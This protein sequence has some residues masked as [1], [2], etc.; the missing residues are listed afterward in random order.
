[1][2]TRWTQ[3][4][5]IL[6]LLLCM[7]PGL[8]G[9]SGTVKSGS[10]PIPGATVRAT[11]D[12][13]VLTTLTDA[14]G[15]F[16]LDKMTPGM[17]RVEVL[18][19]GFE[20][21]RRDVE[22][23]SAPLRLDVALQIGATPAAILAGAGARLAPGGGPGNGPGRGGFAQRGGEGRAGGRGGFPGAAGA[24]FPRRPG[25]PDAGAPGAGGTGP[26][27]QA[28]APQQRGNDN[29]PFNANAANA[30]PAN[31]SPN[32]NAANA[33]P[34]IE[35]GG[36]EPQVDV[37]SEAAAPV[38][39]DASGANESFLVN[40][41]LSTGLNTNEADF[42]PGFGFNGIGA[43]AAAGGAN[44]PGVEG[45]QA[46]P[47]GFG[48][49]IP[50]GFPGGGAPVG[51]PPGGF[52]GG[53]PR[54]GGGG[55]AGPG[56]GGRGPGGPQGNGGFIGNRRNAG[57]PALR[58]SVFFALRNSVADAAPYSINGQTG[59]KAAYAQN[60][61]GANIG[62]PLWGNTFFFLN[63]TGNLLRNG[64]NMTGTVPTLAQRG[65]DFSA[66]G[67]IL[68][69]PQSGLPFLNNQIPLNRI[70]SIAQGLLAYIPAPNQPGTVNN[71]R[72][73][74]AN[75]SNNQALNGRVQ[76]PYGRRDQ[77]GV[78]LNWQ[79]RDAQ[80]AQMFGFTDSS[81]GSGINGNINWRHNFGNARFNNLSLTFNRN[82]STA[83]PY[84]ANGANIAAQLGIQGTSSDPINFGPPNL[85]FTN[86]AG[87]T[88]GSPSRSA[89]T[90]FGFTES[91]LLR[92]GRHNWNL[93]GGLTRT[94]NYTVTD[95]NGRGT[96]TF[97]GLGTSQLN[98]NG[99][100][101]NGTGLDFADFLL[102]LPQ[103][104]SIRY[105]SSAM[106]F[107]SYSW[108]AYAQDDWR[109]NA[110][111]S[112]NLGLRYEYFAP[113]QEKYSR[114][115]NLDIAPGFTAAQV[116]TPGITAPYSGVNA[117]GL[118]QPDR[119]NFGPRTALAY[120]PW[121]KHSTLFR[122]GYGIYYN[123]GIYNQFM[124]RL[125][126][127]PP[128]AQST[129]VTTTLTNPLTLASGLTVLP[130]GKTILNTFAV[131]PLYRTMYAQSW[132]AAIQTNLTAAWVMEVS[133]LGTKG[134]R[135]DV[136]V[137]PNQA[138]PGSPLT[139]LDRTII[140][141]A[142]S[143]VYDTPVGNSIYH[144]GQVR[145]NRRFRRGTSGSVQY[146]FAKSIDNSSTLGGA[147]NSIAQN[148]YNLSAE[149]GL[150]SFNR[151]HSLTGNFVVN[152]PVGGPNGILANRGALTKALTGW[153][154][155][156]SVTLQT[157]TPLTARV[158]GNQSDTA[159]T[160][161][162]GSGRASA[163]GL[164]VDSGSGFFNLAAFTLPAPGQYGNAGRNT[165]PGPNSFTLNASLQRTI[166]LNERIRMQI[167]V[168]ATNVTNHPN[169]TGF[170]TVV[171]SIN[172]GAP[173]SVAGMRTMML[174]LRFNF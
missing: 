102:G 152:S 128:F 150:S 6:S 148:F 134:T 173:T 147:G 160:G 78:G 43:T 117:A 71:F 47:G 3:L 65:G 42:R 18:M 21:M 109:V 121:T 67:S 100:A 57:R 126:Q 119:N 41:S 52:G 157:G 12:D 149:R 16:T 48:G 11:Q 151:S 36:A 69:D 172:Y 125:A 14:N 49:G 35:G 108:N 56:R 146:L 105:G 68:Y 96:F 13:R 136:Q 92:I 75:P 9:Q 20:P 88:D 40:G 23:G 73:T 60:R 129:T 86:Y 154:L 85:N 22:I 51:P 39:A 1:M 38:Q 54:G 82:T 90:S 19:F 163:T 159:G 27:G 50:G 153:T 131:N 107:Q 170:G 138:A 98:A 31:P 30:N 123:P 72:Y 25:A 140:G 4:S 103:S 110:K 130:A 7:A 81:S 122:L 24:G 84:F 116:Y 113:W 142:T 114:I 53:G 169:F 46:Q 28:T 87:L 93:G 161:T 158:L 44:V 141:N 32:E 166:P 127:Q 10:Q 167:R 97:T 74:V 64:A 17:W 70:S 132:N 101:L 106:Y 104:N 37:S 55:F 15:N 115:A 174:T 26:T 164:P 29:R 145:L 155:N 34:T 91:L 139:S 33:P 156:G 59:T 99:Q 2:R 112:L 45:A 83:T 124:M 76:I 79:T 94:N 143:F 137:N 111:L 144:A 118:I 62:G 77:F 168:D 120:K 80:T 61:F 171:N 162:F 5:L 95:S 8:F 89:V 135:L 66:G 133:Y 165:I 63:Y 58:G